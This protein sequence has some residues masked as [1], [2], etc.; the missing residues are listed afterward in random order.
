MMQAF[1]FSAVDY[2]MKPVDEDRLV[3][4]STAGKEK[5]KKEGISGHA[6]TLIHNMNKVG[7][8]CEMRLCLPTLKGFTI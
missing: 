3:E 2:L 4:A 5:I 6:E 1:Q 7:S 8:P